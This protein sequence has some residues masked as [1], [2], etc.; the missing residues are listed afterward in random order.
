[1]TK[2]NLIQHLYQLLDADPRSI[3]L[4][5]RLIEAWDAAGQK[6]TVHAIASDLLAL[7]PTNALALRH[8][9]HTASASSSRKSETPSSS[10]PFRRH[11]QA[12]VSGNSLGPPGTNFDLSTTD[13]RAMAEKRLTEGYAKL[14][15]EAAI[16]SI[17]MAAVIALL[18]PWCHEGTAERR[19]GPDMV[20]NLNLAG[21]GHVHAI[22][23]LTHQP[24]SARE[25][26]RDLS[27]IPPDQQSQRLIDD[28]EHVISWTR[29]QSDAS[30][31][32]HGSNDAIRS[33][34]VKRKILLDALLPLTT[35]ETTTATAL[36]YVE[37]RHL[38]RRY[39][40]DETMLGDAVSDIPA[41]NLLVSEDNYAWDMAELASALEANSGIMRNPLTRKLF[42]ETDVRRILAHPLGQRL[43]PMRDAQTAHL[44]RG[45]HPDTVR[46]VAQMGRVMVAD[47]TLD[48]APSQEV[49]D[50]FLAHV[51]TLPDAE[52]QVLEC[53]K[54]PARDSLN[55]QQFDYTVLQAVHDFKSNLTCV[56][57]IGD[58]FNQAAQ[59]FTRP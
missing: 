6:E 33:R 48:M 3:F 18:P 45:L 43:R 57:K 28:F 15:S 4:H 56:H 35:G 17:E 42:S 14:C 11:F 21:A 8:V 51:A 37:H 52:R 24:R 10:L 5:E 30:P 38:A 27:N 34:L 55:R 29:S 40:N 25:V 13:G 9:H 12:S 20:S 50:E 22:A 31:L 46:L 26:A 44:S 16:L 7:E 1:M 59:H 32:D 53:L 2:T 54:V 49:A 23:A 36:S 19:T 58:F 47:Q 41:A 39:E